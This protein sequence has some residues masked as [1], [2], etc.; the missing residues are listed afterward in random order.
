MQQSLL[1]D[2]IR[3]VARFNPVNWAAEAG[4]S[5]TASTPDWS[6]VATR[7]GFLALVLLASAVFATRAFGAYQ[8][9]I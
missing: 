3:W 6:L 9:S 7:T 8:R 1:P 4:R 2:W 5:A